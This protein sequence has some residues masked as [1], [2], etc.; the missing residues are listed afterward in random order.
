M[1]QFKEYPHNNRYIVYS[2]GR[3]FSKPNKM[4]HSTDGL[5]LKQTID[6]KGYVKVKLYPEKKTI[7]V[8]RMVTITFLDN[9]NNY[10][11]INHKDG[12]KLNNHVDNL[13]WCS[14]K[15]N[16]EHAILTKLITNEM[17]PRGSK[18][19]RSKITEQDVIDIRARCV[20]GDLQN[21]VTAIARDYGLNPTT[22]GDIVNRIIWQHVP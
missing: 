3:I 8:H 14:N 10:E 13:E 11:Q 20:K 12:N 4:N 9:P 18:H 22:V 17:R 5:F 16:A 6:K 21:G 1:I 2:D 15:Q 7:T 19:R